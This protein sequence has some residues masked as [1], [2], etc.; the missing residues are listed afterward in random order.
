MVKVE[1]QDVLGLQQL[2]PKLICTHVIIKYGILHYCMLIMVV[3]S[4]TMVLIQQT[5]HWN[6]IGALV[7]PNGM[8]SHS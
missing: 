5:N 6:A 3:E 7:R 8:T 1:E 4:C 2:S